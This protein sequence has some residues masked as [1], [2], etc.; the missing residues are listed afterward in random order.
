MQTE[1]ELVVDP[2]FN[3]SLMSDYVAS[4]PSAIT[5]KISGA[6]HYAQLSI[7]EGKPVLVSVQ[8]IGTSV[9]PRLGI[10]LDAEGAISSGMIDDLTSRLKR[11]FSL[12]YDYSEF[13]RMAERDPVFSSLV[14]RFYGLRPV[15]IPDP[16]ESLIWA[17]LG[18]QVNVKLARKFKLS[19]L[20]LLDCGF[21]IGGLDFLAS[22]TAGQVAVLTP[23]ALQAERFGGHRASYVLA[24]ANAVKT[25]KINWAHLETL[26]DADA[27]GTL[28]QVRGVGKW[29]AEYVLMRGLGR[30]DIIPAGDL[31]LQKIINKSYSVGD[32]KPEAAVRRISAHWA[33][34]RGWAA[35]YWWMALQ[36]GLEVI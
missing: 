3:F 6:G 14:N 30:R 36:S 8:E 34:W 17:I 21:H 2:P 32:E 25:S 15:L 11:R 33:G 4:S 7:C 23:E 10:R 24:A 22:P 16:F 20:Q 1:F 27:C 12:E 35:F 26:S 31:G 29:T 18:Q 19:L 13:E 5:E 9:S 28:M